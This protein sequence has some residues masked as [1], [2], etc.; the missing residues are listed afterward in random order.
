MRKPEVGD[1]Y[2]LIT[3]TG[4]NRLRLESGDMCVVTDVRNMIDGGAGPYWQCDVL[5]MRTGD[6]WP[7]S[8]PNHLLERV[9]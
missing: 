7:A 6:T 4:P 3:S 2:R 5:F 9:N 1:M 8:I